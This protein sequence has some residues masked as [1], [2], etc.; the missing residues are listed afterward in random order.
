MKRHI[1]KVNALKI[2]AFNISVFKISALQTRVFVL[3]LASFYSN[4]HEVHASN[5]SVTV[6]GHKVEVLQSTPLFDAN[7]IA[8][9]LSNK[10]VNPN[11]VTSKTGNS[12]QAKPLESNQLLEFIAKGWQIKGRSTPCVLSKQ[13]FRLAH[14][15][16]QIQ[17]RYLFE[18][19][20]SEQPQ[21]MALLWLMHAPDDHFII[22]ELTI[23]GKSKT[24]IFQRQE[25]VID[26]LQ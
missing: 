20:E 2:K 1:L 5:V 3:L 16:S 18:C 4:A 21:T 9:N 13:A 23:A 11:S 19:K 17:L 7:V 12:A 24:V 6:S 26:L 25:L 14:H 15:N 8:R 10:G 22:M